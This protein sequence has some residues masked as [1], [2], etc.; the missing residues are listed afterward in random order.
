MKNHSSEPIT[1][2]QR[3][4]T[5]CRKG[6]PSFHFEDKELIEKGKISV[7]SLYTIRKGELAYDNVKDIHR[8]VDADIIKIK[9]KDGTWDCLFLDET[10]NDCTIYKNRPIE[11]RVLKCRDTREIER[12]YDRERLS[13][14]DL[15]SGIEG[16]WEFIADHQQKCAYEELRGLVEDL[17]DRDDNTARQTIC[18]IIAYD[19]QIRKL[20]V[21]KTDLQPDQL[22]FLFGRPLVQTIA[23]FDLKCTEKGNKFI[24]TFKK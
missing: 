16:L 10:T 14:E 9:G 18:E 11:C 13:R 20:V 15:V 17:R 24:L 8:P 21:E 1:T 6:G 23:M 3:C 22:D 7:T 12:I 4:G 19:N 5:C 2:C